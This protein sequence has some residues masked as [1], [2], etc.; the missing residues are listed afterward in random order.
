MKLKSLSKAVL[1]A[2]GVTVLSISL[3]GC[4]D[5]ASD[6]TI[7]AVEFVGMDAPASDDQIAST[8][9][10]AKVRI[11]YSDGSVKEQALDYNV[12]F[13]NTDKVGSSANAAGQ[14]Y[15]YLGSPIMDPYG[16]PVIAE[17]PDGTSLLKIDGA[18]ATGMGGNPLS[19]ITHWEYDWIL[20]NGVEAY[21]EPN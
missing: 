10:T 20:S 18:P 2:L 15:D 1:A 17:T 21:K 6:P 12:L 7:S 5:S 19:L 9:T 13:A 3:T 11:T 8:Y 16:Q 14:Y 4:D